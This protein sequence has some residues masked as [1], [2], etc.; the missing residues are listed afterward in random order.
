MIGKT[1][2]I[3][4]AAA[5]VSLTIA[6]TSATTATDSSASVTASAAVHLLAPTYEPNC[7]IHCVGCEGGKHTDYVEHVIAWTWYADE[8][9]S[10]PCSF[11]GCSTW[12]SNSCTTVGTGG[13][14]A[15]LLNDVLRSVAAGDGSGVSTAIRDY[16]WLAYNP[17]RN[18]IQAVNCSGVL[19]ANIPLELAGTTGFGEELRA[20]LSL[21]Y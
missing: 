4:A 2:T 21:N 10:T 12:H 19:V 5:S 13:F 18:A 8:M 15:E 17:A 6:D 20:A 9:H 3:L 14:A 1:L 16:E 7:N 11:G